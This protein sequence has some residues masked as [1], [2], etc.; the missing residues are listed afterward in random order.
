MGETKRFY[1][2]KL[3]EDFFR[4]KEIKKLRKLAGGDTFTIIYLKM[5]LRSLKDG[6]RLYYEGVEDNFA[7]ELALDIDEDEENV[8]IVVAFLMANNI[9]TQNEPD[10]Y[11]LIT[12]HEMTDSEC[13]SAARV[14][15]LRERKSLEAGGK[16]LLCNGDVTNGNGSV[17]AR[18]VEIDIELE[19]K[20]RVR[21]NKRK[22]ADC[23]DY[24][25]GFEDFWRIYPRKVD[26]KGSYQKW[27]R[28]GADDSKAITETIIADVKRRIDGDWKK[29]DTRYI[30]HPST[31]LN[32]RRWEDEITPTKTEDD[33]YYP[34][35]REYH[36]EDDFKE[37]VPRSAQ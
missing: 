31:Y 16:A 3:K 6:G 19:K 13:D 2:L 33:E 25:V 28:A 32:Q 11:E 8:K 15:R 5:L 7:S 21:E 4:Q 29:T 18:N 26:K 9:L 14:R 20:E 37:P 35:Y 17:T 12:A 36:P 10:E 24:S 34:R 22:R 23:V 30:P 27:L 1:W